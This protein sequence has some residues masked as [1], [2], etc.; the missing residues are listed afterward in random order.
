MPRTGRSVILITAN[1]VLPGWISSKA[2]PHAYSLK[3]K[4]FKVG[5]GKIRTCTRG[6]G[7]GQLRPGAHPLC[8]LHH[9]SRANAGGSFPLNCRKKGEGPALNPP[10]SSQ[11]GP[12]MRRGVISY[13]DSG[14]CWFSLAKYRWIAPTGS[15]GSAGR[16]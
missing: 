3:Q 7:G 4:F 16:N 6:S 1:C 12:L 14:E 15:D 8:Y 5:P 13:G 11:C 10:P 2:H 9:Q